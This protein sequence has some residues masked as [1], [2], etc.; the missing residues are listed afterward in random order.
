MREYVE[1][2]SKATQLEQTI[3]HEEIN[4]KVLEKEGRLKK[5]QT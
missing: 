1:T 2:K 3:Q 4:Q 5:I